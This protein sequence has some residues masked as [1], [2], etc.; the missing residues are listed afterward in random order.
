M[1]KTFKMSDTIKISGKILYK[2]GSNIENCRVRIWDM[3]GNDRSK[4]DLIIDEIT[5]RY[6]QFTGEGVWE[7]EQGDKGVFRYELTLNGK[8]ISKFRITNP[9]KY[10]QRVKTK[11]LSPIQNKIK[12]E[13]KVVYNDGSPMIG[14]SIKIWEKDKSPNG[15]KDDLIVNT[16]TDE[17]GKFKGEGPND[18]GRDN[19]VFRYEII[20]PFT[21]EKAS[22]KKVKKDKLKVISTKI[23]SPDQ[24][25][26]KISG[27]V[28]YEDGS[29]VNNAEVR[30]YEV[31]TV[32]Y[33]DS[34]PNLILVSIT[35]K[36]G[37]YK[38][39]IP[40]SFSD[41]PPAYRYQ[42]TMPQTG[43]VVVDEVLSKEELESIDTQVEK[44]DGTILAGRVMWSNRSPAAGVRIL[45]WE[46][47]KD[48][49]DD[50]V[51]DTRT[52]RDG[53]FRETV[54][55][56]DEG[57]IKSYR[58]QVEIP[59]LEFIQTSGNARL[60]RFRLKFIRLRGNIP[61]W[62]NWIDDLGTLIEEEFRFS[63][64]TEKELRNAIQHR[65]DQNKKIR[66]VGGGHSHS[67]VAKPNRFSSMINM[68][69]LSGELGLY[70]WLKETVKDQLGNG[71]IEN[72]PYKV[73]DYI[74]VKSGTQ[75]RTLYRDILS[76]RDKPLGLLNMGPF[77]GQR[78]G[79]LINTNTHGTGINLPG[80]SDM[81]RS[82]EMFVIIPKSEDINEVQL[83]V[84]EP[85]D[86]ISD[87]EKFKAINPNKRLVQNDQVFYSVVCGYGLFGIVYS[88][89]L[90]VR[91]FYWM[92]EYHTPTDWETFKYEL[93]K[94]KHGIIPEFLKGTYEFE[95]EDES[96][97]K[98]YQQTK[99]YI[100]TSECLVN[101][102]IKSDTRLRVDRWREKPSQFKP[103]KFEENIHPIWPP[104]RQRDGKSN[105]AQRIIESFLKPSDIDGKLP[106]K[107]TLK[108]LKNNFFNK[109]GNTIF[110]R[111]F[112]ET[113]YYRAIRRGRD[114]TLS[115]DKNLDEELSKIDNTKFDAEP[116]PQDY[117]PSIEISVPV[118]KT[119]EAIELMMNTISQLN[120]KFLG[121][122]GLRFTAESKHF[123]SPTYGR[124]TAFIEL[125]GLLPSRSIRNLNPAHGDE[126]SGNLDPRNEEFISLKRRFWPD[127]M[128][129]YVKAM[130]SLFDVMNE[131]I[132]GI[133]FHKG[134]INKYNTS[135]LKDHY[136]DSYSQ[137]M[138]MYLL[139]SASG[140]LDCPNSVEEWKLTD[141]RLNTSKVEAGKQL[142][143][144][145]NS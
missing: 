26:E 134:K 43:E 68:E 116:I 5:D 112:R 105:V 128:D 74:R 91:N 35:N 126:N 14:A 54:A 33:E 85:S 48:G 93:N 138:E 64:K 104:M 76:H 129:I 16:I 88:Y 75:L 19:Q 113:A 13:G 53:S 130:H 12:L 61:G 67:K 144:L 47:D 86:G 27:E 121:P 7:D 52:K 139:F 38:G 106:S 96:K 136:P 56:N 122:V 98:M 21:G 46:T 62:Q 41:I 45:I 28:L 31:D 15:S 108:A 59:E 42:I 140:L 103:D 9:E 100:N 99:V 22:D 25:R 32:N 70:P 123:L 65:I 37:K 118:E 18:D 58:W 133:R 145:A 63:P 39:A 135:L 4:D 78:I 117:G 69:N 49:Q 72:E 95:H 30:I 50:L 127:F 77:D 120:V 17:S 8:T 36:N 137:F 109:K 60:A 11:W 6:G 73:C 107:F 66:V 57:G 89:T 3:D 20:D 141:L 102:G 143:A 10:F 111:G 125:A 1:T 114:N 119:V 83:W 29:P 132:E 55:W 87:P 24:P 131:N 82:V 71:Q 40:K 84:I 51:I 110:M 2:D 44:F 80:F 92:D 142:E 101:G 115:F 81:V 79:G 94:F 124:T 97:E 23:K 90:A 34:I